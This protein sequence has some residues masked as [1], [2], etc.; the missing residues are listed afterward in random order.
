MLR[1]TRDVLEI[2]AHNQCGVAIKE[3]VIL[4]RQRDEIKKPLNKEPL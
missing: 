4:A 1:V 2:W 3:R